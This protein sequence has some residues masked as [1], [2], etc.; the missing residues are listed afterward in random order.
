MPTTT[1][2]FVRLATRTA[3]LVGLLIIAGSCARKLPPLIFPQSLYPAESYPIHTSVAGFVVGAVPYV[4]GVGMNIDPKQPTN[5]PDDVP[6]NLLEAGVLP[7]RLILTNRRD[8]EIMIDPSQFFCLNG[9][10]PYKSYPPQRAV[11]LVVQSETFKN[12]LKGTSIG[13]LLKSIFGGELIFNAATSSVGGVVRG[14]VTGGASGAA[15]SATGT[16]MKRAN[17]YEN[18]L[19]KLLYEQAEIAA[20]KSQVLLPG[21]TTDG[22]LYCP[23]TVG[24]Q[25]I[26]LTV[27]DRTNEQP[28]SL[29]CPLQ[30]PGNPNGSNGQAEPAADGNVN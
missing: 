17:Q 12:A 19:A 20:L 5:A 11:G 2:T 23:S 27:Y 21:F 28:L 18:A 22:V 9:N 10:T 7:I 29:F 25:A 13:P 16:V 15:T 14:G 26:R 8:G 3:L 30:P 1:A 24:V 6:L 4:P